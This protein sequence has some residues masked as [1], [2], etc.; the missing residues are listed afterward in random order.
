MGSSS[1]S[2]YTTVRKRDSDSAEITALQNALYSQFTPMASQLGSDYQAASEKASE[3]Q[4]NYDSAYSALQS[5][6]ES[7][8][9]PSG[10]TSAMESYITRAM[11]KSLGSAMASS[12]ANG[13]LN[14]SVTSK[15]INEIGTNTA[16]ALASNYLDAYNAASG[17]YSTLMDSSLAAQS[18]LYSDL[19]TKFSPLL[20]FYS[21]VRSSED[22]EDYDTVVEQGGK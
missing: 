21:T 8:E 7:G 9:L 2:T 18:Q 22:Q 10:L 6:I 12:A 16:D 15:A 14:S 17:N 5:L 19:A 13:V 3:Y 1:S 11:N 4:S 20:E